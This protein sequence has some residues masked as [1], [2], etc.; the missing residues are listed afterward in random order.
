MLIRIRF[1]AKSTPLN[2][3]HIALGEGLGLRLAQSKQVLAKSGFTGVPFPLCAP[4]WTGSPKVSIFV[5]RQQRQEPAWGHSFCGRAGRAQ[6]GAEGT[7]EDGPRGDLH[8]TRVAAQ[9]GL[10]L[11]CPVATGRTGWREAVGRTIPT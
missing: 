5:T 6:L 7:R 4:L 2:R 9:E 8:P 3:A 11:R 1:S 10:L